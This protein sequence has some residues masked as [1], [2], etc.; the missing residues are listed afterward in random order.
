MENVRS[1]VA[2]IATFLFSV[3][4]VLAQ[5]R[6]ELVDAN[7]HER[8]LKL[9]QLVSRLDKECTEVVYSERNEQWARPGW[10]VWDARC[11]TGVEYSVRFT[12]EPD[13]EPLVI[14][15]ALAVISNFSCFPDPA[16]V[17]G[18]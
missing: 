16:R 13:H 5:P 6:A 1:V 17:H 11:T 2:A 14:P 7:A 10:M 18:N 8:N 12:A 15:C 9:A 3:T 4:S